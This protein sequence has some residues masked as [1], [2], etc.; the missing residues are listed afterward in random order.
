MFEVKKIKNE[1]TKNKVL[2]FADSDSHDNVLV[3]V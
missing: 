3:Y 1:T 2:Y